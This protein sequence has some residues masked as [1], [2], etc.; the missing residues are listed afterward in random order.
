MMRHGEKSSYVEASIY[1]RND[2]GEEEN[3]VVSREV[4]ALGRNICKINGRLVTVNELK[5]FMTNI[6]DIHGQNDNQTILDPRSHIVFLDDYIGAQ[7]K[8]IKKEYKEKYEIYQKILLELKQNY[9]DEIEKQRK[10]DLLRYQINEIDEASLKNGEE[11]QIES[12]L[13]IINN[14]EK[15]SQNLNESYYE[16]DNNILESLNNVLRAIDKISNVDDKYLEL[17]SRIRSS[18]YEIEEAARDIDAYKDDID[19]DEEEKQNLDE[20]L[21]LIQELKR[22]YGN[23]IDEIL[24]YNEKIKK[25]LFDIENLDEYINK[26][27]NDKLNIEKDL[28][29]LGIKMSKIR[30]KFAIELSNSINIELNDMEM[31]S[32]KFEVQILDEEKFNSNGL[33]KIEF[34]ITTNVGEEAKPL[35]KIASGGEMSRIMLGIKKILSDVDKVPVLIFDEIDTGISGVAAKK[36]GYKIKEISKKHQV[37]CVTH[38]ATIVARGDYNYF[39]SKSVENEKTRTAIKL[40]DE[41]EVLKEIARISTGEVTEISLNHAKEL[42]KDKVA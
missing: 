3:I 25:E 27:K 31:K 30:K 22:K 34:L 37:I 20:R 6:I 23:T 2:D 16:M 26:L 35:I 14:S 40:L 24:E 9:G 19:I 36:V 29:E 12:K 42:R 39:I 15:I 4:N 7:I 41:N 18:Y 13:R 5:E 11:E 28:N 21:D 32:A 17:S 8:G 10:I 38:L 1:V 33:N